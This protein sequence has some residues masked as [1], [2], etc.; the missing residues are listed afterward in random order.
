MIVDSMTH[1]EVYREL[2]RDR[3]GLTRWWQYQKEALRR[4][5]LKSNSKLFPVTRWYDHTSPRHIRYLVTF[6]SIDKRM[7]RTMLGIGALR[8]MPDGI[9]LY[10]AWVGERCNIRKSVFIP[11]VWKRYAER[12][13]V[14]K[15]GTDLIRHFFDNN[16]YNFSASNIHL[17][18]RS[19]R[20]NGE[21]HRAICV[22]EGV[23]LGHVVDGVFIART[24]I[25]Y[26]MCGG[27]QLQELERFRQMMPET[28]ED[29]HRMI[30]PF[31]E[32]E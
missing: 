11:H 22:N 15:T 6:T 16:N 30:I 18:A 20:Y 21:D 1:A 17:F 19:V 23:V 7:I 3:E 29:Y 8:R 12:C 28:L 24:F 25:T 14:E 13:G 31:I 10:T 4:P 9:T 26:D 2:E 27:L 5:L 32:H